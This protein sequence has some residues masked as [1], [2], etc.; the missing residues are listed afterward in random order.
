MST[1]FSSGFVGVSTQTSFVSDRSA[2]ESAS[3]IGLV[4]HVVLEPEASEH[5][6]HEPVGAAVE[7]ARQDHVVARASR[8]AVSSAC[9]AAMPLEN[10]QAEAA[11]ELAQG[12]RSSAARVGLAERA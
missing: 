11:L 9:V 10:A 4:D 2:A 1:T 8:R 3:E 6:V 12:A 5:L 7:V